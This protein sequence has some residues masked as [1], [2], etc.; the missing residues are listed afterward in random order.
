MLP[1]SPNCFLD[2]D[3]PAFA[4]SRQINGHDG[5][6]RTLLLVHLIE[7]DITFTSI[8]FIRIA[9]AFIQSGSQMRKYK[10]KGKWQH[11]LFRFPNAWSGI[12]LT[13]HSTD[14]FIVRHNI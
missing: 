6:D 2:P 3:S 8:T 4:N 10:Q 9:D 11:M 5:K 12:P 14:Y 7:Y 1:G 13:V